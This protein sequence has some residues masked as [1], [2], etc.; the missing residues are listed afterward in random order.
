VVRRTKDEAQETRSAILDTA[1]RVFS[2]RGVSRTSLADIAK[3]AGVTRGAIYWHFKDKADLFCEM[4][5]RVTLPMEDAPC[6]ADHGK[7]ADPLASIRAMMVAILKR[8][9]E[10]A[11][12]RRVFHIVFHKCEYVD[13]MM[14][15]W[16]R[17]ADMQVACLKAIEQGLRAAVQRGQLARELDTRRAALGLHAMVDGLMSKW[18]S[19]PDHV[20]RPHE[21]EHVVDLFLAG[22]RTATV[23]RRARHEVRQPAR[24]A[25]N[26]GGRRSAQ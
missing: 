21:A 5:A 20:P 10:D 18:V 13:E 24:A 9:S 14:V 25:G 2:S 1:E 19:D 17:F 23:P 15:V 16:Q 4:V 3:A 7:A 11:Q 6:R 8:T 26:R 12:A 22:L